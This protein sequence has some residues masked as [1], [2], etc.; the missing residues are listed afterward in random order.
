LARP[1]VCRAGGS[2]AGGIATEWHCM[3]AAACSQVLHDMSCH[4]AA[5]IVRAWACLCALLC[6]DRY[7]GCAGLVTLHCCVPDGCQQAISHTAV[8]CHKPCTRAIPKRAE[9]AYR[10]RLPIPSVC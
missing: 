9:N 10:K 2:C 4:V 5:G 6:P 3:R 7:C 8:Y 1:Q